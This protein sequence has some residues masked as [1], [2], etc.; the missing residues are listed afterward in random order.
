[1]GCLEFN[2]N[3]RLPA[4]RFV[5]PIVMF[6]R[7]MGW[8]CNIMVK[9]MQHTW[10]EN[11]ETYF[12]VIEW[13]WLFNGVTQCIFVFIL[14]KINSWTFLPLPILS[15]QGPPWDEIK[16]HVLFLRSSPSTT[17]AILLLILALLCCFFLL[18][19]KKPPTLPSPSLQR[20]GETFLLH[21]L[22]ELWHIAIASTL[23]SQ[24]FVSL[25][26][27]NSKR[28]VFVPIYNAYLEF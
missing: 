7:L 11:I 2:W 20:C 9:V 12:L 8:T 21:L 23:P 22:L 17:I 4:Q 24:S 25:S 15:L 6:S 16:F 19:K 26:T 3:L 28:G 13:S 5:H 18:R 27:W 10:W 14:R 1:M